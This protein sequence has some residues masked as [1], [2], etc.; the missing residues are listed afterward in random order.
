MRNRYGIAVGV[1]VVALGTV[2]SSVLFT[3]CEEEPEPDTTI[4]TE[5]TWTPLAVPSFNA[6]SAYQFIQDQVDF[7]PRYAGT[8]DNPSPAHDSCAIYLADKLEGY[9]FE[10]LIQ[11][12]EMAAYNGT[13]LQL[14]NIIGQYKPEADR[15]VLLFAHWDTRH[16]ADKE[17]ENDLMQQPILGADDGGSGVGVLLEIARLIQIEGPAIGV[18]IIFFDGEDYGQ[19]G[20][21][22]MNQGKED[23]WCLGTQYW[24]R[25]LQPEGYDADYGILLDMVGAKGAVFPKEGTS[26]NYAASIVNKVWRIAREMGHSSYFVNQES[27]PT[28]DDHLYVNKIAHIPSIDIVY[29]NPTTSSYGPHHHTLADNMDIIDKATLQAVGETLM[30]VI[31]AEK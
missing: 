16:V 5:D 30:Q 20:S 11:R 28:I 29:F 24:A 15:R 4:I 22:L 26:M 23:T 19:P 14:Q 3:G 6:D 10:V 13:K 2:G 25:N 18:D 27:A 12:G 31:Y 9:G 21:D 8:L 17:T 1:A 7:G